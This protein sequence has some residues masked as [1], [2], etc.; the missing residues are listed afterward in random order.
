MKTFTVEEANS[1]IGELSEIF[2]RISNSNKRINASKFVTKELFDYKK[3]I[4][5]KVKKIERMG[6]FVK[7]LNQGLVDFLFD[8]D[9]EFVY[10]CWKFGEDEIKYWHETGKGYAGRLPI[11]DLMNEEVL[12]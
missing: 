11:E 10:L 1:L 12:E 6:C 2:V 7:D 8:D 3:E 9:G 4:E 5:K